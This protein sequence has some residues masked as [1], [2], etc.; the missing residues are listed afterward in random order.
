MAGQP[1]AFLD[2]D[3][4]LIK[5][6]HYLSDPSQAVLLPGAVEGLQ[7]LAKQGFLLVVLSNQSGV[8]RGY[9]NEEAVRAVNARVHE[10]LHRKGVTIAA[11]Y[12]CPHAPEQA[13]HCRK[14]LPGLID[15]ACADFAID[16]S[17]SL[18]IGDKDVDLRLAEGRGLP[19]YLISS[20][21]SSHA[22]WAKAH[23][24][25]VFADLAETACHITQLAHER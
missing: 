19:G 17:R 9:F 12:F 10:M 13:C 4:T 16:L 1:C 2:R 23:H 24:Y 11:W 8:G 5:D 14:P 3:G 20:Q 22:D 18:M 7:S 25:D 21:A 6:L 15:Q